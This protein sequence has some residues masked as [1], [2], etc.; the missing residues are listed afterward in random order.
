MLALLQRVNKSEVLVNNK[1]VNKISKGLLVFLA[2]GPEDTESDCKRLA[3]RIAGYRI[4]GDSENKMNLSLKDTGGKILLVSQFTLLADTKKGARPS[5][6]SV[7]NP[8]K[9][10]KLYNYMVCCFQSLEIDVETGVFKAHMLIKIENDGPV[11]FI[12]KSK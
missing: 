7:A 5:F 2:V 3:K 11:T 12:L 1:L 8:Q 4:F 6:S 10:E 9:A